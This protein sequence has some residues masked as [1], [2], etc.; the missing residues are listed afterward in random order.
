MGNEIYETDQLVSDYLFFHYAKNGDFMPWE[1]GPQDA[2]GFPQR[3]ASYAAGRSYKRVLDL[4]CSVGR[5]SF[6]LTKY[7]E[8]V[9]GVDYSHA[10][11]KAASSLA[12]GEVIRV[13]RRVGEFVL[14]APDNCFA[15][16]VNFEQGDAMDLSEDLGTFDLVHASNLLCRLPSPKQFLQTLPH[17]VNAGGRVILAT[18]FSWL[19][20]YTP[21]DEWP[22]GDSWAWLQRKMSDQFTLEQEADEPFM[23]REHARKY[24]WCVSKVSVW[25]KK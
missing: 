12:W 22:D 5:S 14:A 16:K 11:I 25:Q 1:C 7:A 9:L 3:T 17:L 15:S 2:L 24:Q 13:K 23:I 8:H 10:F 4:G 20:E 21:R 6:E 19:E 18:P